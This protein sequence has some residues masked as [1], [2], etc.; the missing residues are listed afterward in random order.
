[1]GGGLENLQY[2][3]EGPI[4]TLFRAGNVELTLEYNEEMQSL[5]E[6]MERDV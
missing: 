6:Q 5:V 3:T 1:L 4:P 2:G